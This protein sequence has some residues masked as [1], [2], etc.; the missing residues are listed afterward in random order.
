MPDPTAILIQPSPEVAAARQALDD[1]VAA[2]DAISPEYPQGVSNYPTVD[3]VWLAYV[4]QQVRVDHARSDLR[5]AVL[6]HY[7]E[8]TGMPTNPRRNP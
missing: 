1:A 8:L 3:P 6:A 7:T 5:W 4:H 2:L